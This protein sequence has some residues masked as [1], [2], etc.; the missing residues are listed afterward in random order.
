MHKIGI[1]GFGV[2]GKSVLSFLRQQTQSP[3]AVWDGRELTAEEQG[4]LRQY[5]AEKI[6]VTLPEF[7]SLHDMLV[8]SPGVDVSVCGAHADKIIGELDL[9]APLMHK[10]TVAITG[11]LG[12]TTIT[13]LLA[14][15]GSKLMNERTITGGNIG[16]GMLDLLQ[17]QDDFDRAYLELSSF[18][19]ESNKTY[20]PDVAVWTN[21]YPNHLD[22]HKTIDA[23]FA[24]KLKL[25]QFQHEGQWALLPLALFNTLLATSL[26]SSIAL[27]TDT[28]PEAGSLPVVT[29]PYTLFYLHNNQLY[30]SVVAYGKLGTASFVCS[31]DS[32][33]SLSYQQNWVCVLATLS[34][35]GADLARLDSIKSEL[36][37]D[38][39]HHRLE[40]CG[41]MNGVDFYN[42]S[43]STLIQATQAAVQECVRWGRPIILI[44][45]GLGKG[46]DRTP[47]MN[48]L[49]T[50]A[51]V[52]RVYCYGPECMAFEGAI[53]QQSLEDILK[54]IREIMTS[55]DVVLFSPSGTSFD[56]YKNYAHRG[57]VFKALVKA[58]CVTENQK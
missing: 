51:L 14:L 50:V 36:V 31:F 4:L 18:Q 32:L 17:R 42:D 29:V 57:D 38:D 9:F 25:F 43:K 33:P 11:S 52:K 2:V 55:G 21:F 23:Y 28:M 12:K 37:L 34:L 26:K 58:L 39:H 27:F 10:P 45:G 3:I 48:Y 7:A 54:N 22:R 40:H 46:A 47:L 6:D 16:V 19:L 1:L 53:V 44:L 41:R 15:L 24:S 5:D 49:K 56:L 8:A 30:R 20:A 13:K 35:L